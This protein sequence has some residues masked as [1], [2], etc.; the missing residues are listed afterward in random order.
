VRVFYGHSP[1]FQL[2]VRWAN[3][4][5]KQAVV[6]IILD[7]EGLT[8]FGEGL[9]A[10]AVAALVSAGIRF[11]MAWALDY[12]AGLTS[13]PEDVL[14]IIGFRALARVLT[15]IG[16]KANKMGVSSQSTGKDGL[17]RSISVA[18]DR[19]QRVLQSPYMQQMMSE[20]QLNR[21]RKSLKPGIKVFS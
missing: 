3:E 17:S 15:I 4:S 5:H 8:M 1:L 21:L 19:Y 12:E 18:A 13:I 6:R 10:P 20:D 16:T 11:P 9:A 14:T 7:K 2:P